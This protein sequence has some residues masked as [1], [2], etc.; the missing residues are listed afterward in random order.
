MKIEQFRE[1]LHKL[2]DAYADDVIKEINDTE[3]DMPVEGWMGDFNDWWDELPSDEETG[4]G[5]R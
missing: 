4:D 2:A 1:I 5:S 3:E